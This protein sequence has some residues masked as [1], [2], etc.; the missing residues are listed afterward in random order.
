M[1]SGLDMRRFGTS[2]KRY[3]G[4]AGL[5]YYHHFLDL[6]SKNVQPVCVIKLY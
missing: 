2:G 3:I 5:T 6:K 4:H 1:T